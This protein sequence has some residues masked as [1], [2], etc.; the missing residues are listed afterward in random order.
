MRTFVKCL[1]LA[2]LLSATVISCQKDNSV[3]PGDPV[4]RLASV[5]FLD[6]LSIGIAYDAAGRVSRVTDF[7][8]SVEKRA[9]VF[10]YGQ[11]KITQRDSIP[12]TASYPAYLYTTR[13]YEIGANGFASVCY[14][15]DY[16]AVRDTTYYTYNNDGYLTRSVHHHYQ[17]YQ[18]NV[19]RDYTETHDYTIDGGNRVK[20]SLT[21]RGDN[22]N[23]QS[24]AVYTY[25]TG[26]SNYYGI[27]FTYYYDYPFLGKKNV[28][29]LKSSVGWHSHFPTPDQN[30]FTYTLGT[31]GRPLAVTQT[32][33]NGTGLTSFKYQCQ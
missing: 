28:S 22:D 29:L 11:G 23:Y 7:D 4:C 17:A 12:A 14:L 24:T 30:N 20:D 16:A 21:W 5:H 25:N 6:S 27:N 2:I 8:S 19:H 26:Q 15:T 9:E 1:S 10:E 18:G 31:D 3:N 32:N 13:I 33:T